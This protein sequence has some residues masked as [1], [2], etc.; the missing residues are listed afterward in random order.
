MRANSGRPNESRAIIARMSLDCELPLNETT[1]MICGVGASLRCKR[2]ERGVCQNHRG[3][4]FDTC[5]DCDNSF[6][7]Q[8]VRSNRALNEVLVR[9]RASGLPVNAQALKLSPGVSGG[10]L[11]RAIPP[12]YTPVESGWTLGTATFV[13][14]WDPPGDSMTQKIDFEAHAIA[15]WRE[16][17]TPFSPV[18]LP[19]RLD[20]AGRF[21][22]FDEA[23]RDYSR[24]LVLSDQKGVKERLVNSIEHLMVVD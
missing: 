14:S 5:S 7:A 13:R 11:K 6:H 16:P 10:F 23:L 19:C 3:I 4:E 22:A 20:E 18:I 24:T 17:E 9:L 2:C 8:S 12:E 21:I 1:T 15:L